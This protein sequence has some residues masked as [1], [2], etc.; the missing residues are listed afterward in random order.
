MAVVRADHT[1]A[2]DRAHGD[3]PGR[4]ADRRGTASPF[5][6]GLGLFP[7]G[8][9]IGGAAPSMEVLVLARVL[10]G[11]GAGAIPAV[12]YTSVGRAYPASM[13]PRVSR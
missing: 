12:A 9:T 10:Q 6:L 2:L 1:S 3:A 7:A 8:I 13:Q 11:L 4:A 5:V